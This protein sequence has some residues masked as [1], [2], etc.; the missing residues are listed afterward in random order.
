MAKKNKHNRAAQGTAGLTMHRPK[1][2]AELGRL[3]ADLQKRGFVP[4]GMPLGDDSQGALKAGMPIE[5]DVPVHG[6]QD[7]RVGSLNVDGEMIRR[8]FAFDN[9]NACAVPVATGGTPGLGY[10]PWGADNNLPVIIPGLAASLPYTASP[11]RYLIDLSV[12]LGPK[13]TYRL[14]QV[15]NGRVEVVRLPYEDAGDVLWEAN[16]HEE[17]NAWKK[18]LPEVKK[19]LEENDLALH[20]IGCMQDDAHM[21]IYFPTIGLSRGRAGA[22][23]PKIVSIGQLENSCTRFEQMNR[24]RHINYVYY[25]QRWRYD[26]GTSAAVANDIVAYPAVMPQHRLREL[27]KLVELHQH[28]LIKDRPTWICLPTLYPSGNRSYYPQPAWW[29]IYPSEAFSYISTIFQDKNNARKNKTMFGKV[30]Y[31]NM[32]YLNTLFAQRGAKTQEE[33]EK[34]RRELYESV[35]RFLQRRENHGKLM[36]M[37]AWIEADKLWK[38]VELVDVTESTNDQATASEKELEGAANVIFLALGVDPRLVGVALSGASNG[39][40]FQRELSL[41]KQQQLSSKQRLYLNFLNIIPKFNGWPRQAEF[42]IE[43]QVLTTLDRSKTGLES[44]ESVS[45]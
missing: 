9:I 25:S 7:M 33:Q 44:T 38:S 28:D 22:W 3:S 24:Y 4:M 1:N 17:Y 37:D 35:N 42:I 11:L 26:T 36:V 5:G 43:Q 23:K 41:L 34:V 6:A 31:I 10:V 40:T 19:F 8:A 12:G 15:R 30:M 39:G 14:S 21:D 45:E 27:N 29:S 32:N 2:A 16:K 13:L 20:H 18:S